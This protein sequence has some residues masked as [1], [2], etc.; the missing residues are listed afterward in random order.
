MTDILILG[1]GYAGLRTAKQLNHAHVDANITLVS[2][3][4]YHYESTSLHEVAAGTK[5][6][7]EISFPIEEAIPNGVKFIQGEVETIDVD[8]KSVA[9]K[10]QSAMTYD[11]LVIGL[12]FV[13]E[14]FGI[15]GADEFGL[16][17]V[18][19]TTATAAYQHLE[20]AFKHYN[21]S[22][23]P[24]D[25][26]V[27]VCGAGFT[28]IEYLGEL[29]RKVP[30]LVAAYNLPADQIEITCVEA[31]PS[32][33][34]MFD[35]DL[36][37]YAVKVLNDRGVKLMTGTAIKEVKQNSLIIGENDDEIFANTIIW[38][39]GV[40]GSEVIANSGFDQRRNRVVVNNDLTMKEHPEVYIIGD[41][42]AVM[43]AASGRPY[44]TTAQIAIQ[45][46]DTTAINIAHS[47]K[48]EALENFV[49]HNKGTICSIG[50]NDGIAQLGNGR[51]FRGYFASFLKKVVA[52]R[53]ILLV[54]TAG[55]MF[56]KGR[57]DFYH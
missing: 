4:T 48:N 2:K 32:I 54:S 13:S 46:G 5:T 51:K 37:G 55:E 19:P 36:A 33:L 40:K 27:I 57:F 14:T 24:N 56:K 1:G 7:E 49:F 34:P 53:S 44:P 39:T 15:K 12:G 43:D 20:N 28:S 31:A 47:L 18:D 52:D 38:T 6:A 29:T 3:E 11:Y 17:L 23:D 10:G 22:K 9:I 35:K 41:V 25:L 45:Q 16:P 30:K 21:E 26:H 50:D 42:T 8:Q